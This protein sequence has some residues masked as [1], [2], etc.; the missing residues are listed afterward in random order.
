MFAVHKSSKHFCCKRLF[1]IAEAS[2]FLE[3][4]TVLPQ[5]LKYR[6]PTAIFLLCSFST[7]SNFSEIVNGE[8][9]IQIGMHSPVTRIF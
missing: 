4:R 7:T 5:G 2:S 6:G 1:I 3:K 8:G 9:N